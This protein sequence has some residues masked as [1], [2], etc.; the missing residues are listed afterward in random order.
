M[1][2]V[3]DA[4]AWPFRDPQWVSKLLVMGLI[5]II[6][7][8]GPMNGLGWML[9]ALDRLR[10]GEERLPPANFDHLGRGVRLF[11]VYLVYYLAVGLLAAVIY[12]PS[13][14]ILTAQGHDNPNPVLVS[15]GV[16][17][18][19]VDYSFL[20][21]AGLVLTFATPAIVLAFDRTG[22]AGGLNV[23]GVVK[24]AVSSLANTLIAGLML[25]A[26]AIVGSLG[27]V[28][29]FVGV[30]FTQAYALAMQAW[31][32]RSF[33]LASEEVTGAGRATA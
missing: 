25:I 1:E 13:L 18:L 31:I 24:L 23:K 14:L 27:F 8:V 21:L 6:P 29:C 5:L 19:L 11:V 30:F 32:I 15:L 3:A 28:V 20:S 22:I 12:V 16:G 7:I 33:E 26:A 10:A 9:A 17:L 4:F 2:R